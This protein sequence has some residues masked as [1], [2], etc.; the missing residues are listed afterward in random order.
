MAKLGAP[1]KLAELDSTWP[2]TDNE[3][4]LA[5]KSLGPW[6]NPDVVG[7]QTLD[8]LGNWH[9]QTVSVEIKVNSQNWQR[10]I[11]EAVSHRRYFDRSYFC[12]PVLANNRQISEEM[13]D[14]AE[15][16]SV[17]VLLIELADSEIPKLNQGQDLDENN[18]SVTEVCPAPY[19]PVSPKYRR[20]SFDALEISGLE[21]LF[22]WG[23]PL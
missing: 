20:L 19:S 21:S 15:L 12:Y 4:L 17:G 7:I 16:Y 11:F 22:D 1:R 8:I 9:V 5:G 18:L 23:K 6:G 3:A 13:K 10:D 14:Y 2:A